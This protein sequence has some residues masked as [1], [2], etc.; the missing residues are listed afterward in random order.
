[1]LELE[2]YSQQMEK[3]EKDMQEMSVSL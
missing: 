3:L 2:Q 1:M